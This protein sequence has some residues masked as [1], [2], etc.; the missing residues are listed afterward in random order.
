[1]DK[2]E[3]KN[4]FLFKC[5][6]RT[7]SLQVREKCLSCWNWTFQIKVMVIIEVHLYIHRCVLFIIILLLLLSLVEVI[8]TDASTN[9]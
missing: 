4:I 9:K 1:M 2:F 8:N 5:A 3:Q 6:M 7:S